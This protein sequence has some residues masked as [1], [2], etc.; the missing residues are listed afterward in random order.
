M[1]ELTDLYYNF[2]VNLSEQMGWEERMLTD[3][4]KI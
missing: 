1:V 2:T 3:E 4:N